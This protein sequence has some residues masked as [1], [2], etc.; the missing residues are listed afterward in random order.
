VLPVAGTG[1]NSG[2]FFQACWDIEPLA[3]QEGGD[4]TTLDDFTCSIHDDCI[5][6]MA[7]QNGEELFSSCAAEPGTVDACA[8]LTCGTGYECGVSCDSTGACAPA[9]VATGNIGTC[10]GTVVCQRVSPSCPSGTTPGIL[11]GCYSGYCIPDSECTSSCPSFTTAAS[12][13]AA[14]CTAVFMGSGCTC[15]S[16]GTCSCTSETFESCQ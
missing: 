1:P 12:C 7:P 3:P 8:G 13:E 6:I 16:N 11:N 10:S 2:P 5:S 14:N 9:C 15:Y 4:C